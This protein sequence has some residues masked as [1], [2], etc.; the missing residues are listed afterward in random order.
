MTIDCAVREAAALRASTRVTGRTTCPTSATRD[1]SRLDL[2]RAFETLSLTRS[3]TTSP[4]DEGGAHPGAVQPL[5]QPALRPR[6]PHPGDL[7]ARTTA[8]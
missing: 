8:S 7:E 3:T 4:T 6:V 2:D 5:R 1:A